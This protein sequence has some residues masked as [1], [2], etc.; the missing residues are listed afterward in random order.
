MSLSGCFGSYNLCLPTAQFSIKPPPS[1]RAA[2]RTRGFHSGVVVHPS[3]ALPFRA[4]LTSHLT[5]TDL[6][7]TFLLTR[8]DMPSLGHSRA[9][10]GMITHVHACALPAHRR[11]HG[12]NPVPN[13]LAVRSHPVLP[14]SARFHHSCVQV[15]DHHGV[16]GPLL[17]PLGQLDVEPVLDVHFDG[18][19]GTDHCACGCSGRHMVPSSRCKWRASKGGLR[20]ASDSTYARFL[21]QSPALPSLLWNGRIFI[22][23]NAEHG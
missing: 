12:V 16:F 21:D 4:S 8:Y 3:S 18:G 13:V 7:A 20:R 2:G 15:S 10:A 23:K 11:N 6:V 9:H 1:S 19:S 5:C 22:M 17:T 14:H